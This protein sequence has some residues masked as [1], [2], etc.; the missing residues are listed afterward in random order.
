M[1]PHS[2]TTTWPK[3]RR[4]A[5]RGCGLG[6]AAVRR[7]VFRGQAIGQLIETHCP[8]NKA[9]DQI[10]VPVGANGQPAFALYMRRPDGP[11]VR[12]S[13]RC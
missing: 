2:K 4:T 5:E 1:W 11:Y 9:G 7:L 8:A 6:D 12:S 10:M 3:D 13:F